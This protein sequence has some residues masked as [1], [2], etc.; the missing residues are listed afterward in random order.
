MYAFVDVSNPLDL[1]FKSM[2]CKTQNGVTPFFTST[3]NPACECVS[4]LIYFCHSLLISV[5]KSHRTGFGWLNDDLLVQVGNILAAL[6][7]AKPDMEPIAWTNAVPGITVNWTSP[8]EV[9]RRMMPATFKTGKKNP[10]QV[11][12]YVKYNNMQSF[13][14]CILPMKSQDPTQYVEGEQAPS[15]AHFEE[16][17]TDE[18]AKAAG[19]VQ[20]FATPYSNRIEGTDG[21]MFGR[22]VR[23]E[24]LQVFSYDIYRSGF[25]QYKGDVYDWHGIKLRRYG[26][27]A[28][29]MF[30]STLNPGNAQYYA[31]GISGVENLTQA[32]NL[33][34]YASFPHFLYGDSRLAEAVVG[35]HPKEEWHNSQVDLEPQTG[36]IA[37]ATKRIQ[38]NYLMPSTY[39]PTANASTLA[40]AQDLCGQLQLVVDFMHQ[41]NITTNVTISCNS[42]IAGPTLQCLSIPSNWTMYGGEVYVPYGYAEEG[43]T[44]P[45][46]TA[47]DL[48]S[49]L[50]LVD[51]IADGFRFW[52]LVVAG[53]CFAVL[54]AMTCSSH[55]KEVAVAAEKEKYRGAV[56]GGSEPLLQPTG[57][58][59]VADNWG[60][61]LI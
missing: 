57:S 51:D 35:M 48:N 53:I 32:L 58:R 50:F 39:L 31:N 45:Q 41:N 2:L 52:C 28:M 61:D 24:F 1:F 4:C 8:S 6:Q 30:N 10:R 23:T 26:I 34:V 16:S 7:A 59:A 38:V 25:M 12:Q 11:G 19:Y 14:N 36:L 37:R 29:D 43:I 55:N 5:I 17:W 3:P 9:R 18:Q 13:W 20:P 42:T 49:S 15:C 60:K 47:D 44:M 22:P 21:N 33:P 46:S 54:L 56:A 40:A 27:Q